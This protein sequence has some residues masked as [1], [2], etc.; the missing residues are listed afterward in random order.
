MATAM[1]R[2]QAP[3]EWSIAAMEA[4]GQLLP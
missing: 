1:P 2:P 3:D 4:L